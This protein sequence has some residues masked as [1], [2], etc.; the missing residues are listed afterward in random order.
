MTS[1]TLTKT[2]EIIEQHN[3]FMTINFARYP[4]AMV[5]G[6]GSTLWD[7]EGKEY[8]DLFAG[9][10]A[11]VMGHCHPD[12]VEAVTAQAKTLWHV[13][14]LFHTEPQTHLAEAISRHG[15]GGRSFFCH[16]GADANEAAIK[17][18][19][20]Y[21][22]ANPGPQGPRFKVISTIDS[23]HGR[24]FATMMATGQD[25]VRAGYEPWLE[26]FSHVPYNNLGAMKAAID[27]QTV[28]IIVEPIQGEGG[29]NVPDEGYLP[30]LRR[31]AD[32]HNLVLIFDEVWT[33]C[34]RT[35]RYFAHQYWNAVPDVMTL[36]KGVGGGLAVGVMCAGPRVADRFDY[37]VHH[38]VAHATTLGGNCLSMA[39][40]AAVFKVL[41]RDNLVAKA[42][43]LGRHA[44]DR[45]ARFAKICPAV[46]DVRGRGLFIGIELNPA[47]KGAWFKSATEVVNKA[48]ER[49]LLIN[50]TQNTVLRLAPPVVITRQELDRGLDLLE[51]VIANA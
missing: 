13:G 12:I 42:E 15:F 22:R 33:G 31:L 4:I 14:N 30:G 51:R 8:L 45:M 16:S 44:M 26:G 18:S 19:R 36:A 41:E 27:A 11:G 49:G 47:A 38:G 1:D 10:G 28:A 48:M 29:I 34:G 3:K 35:G 21:G 25:K 9:F 46:K 5:R 40:A 2:H 23:F 24:T 6:Q 39:A 37:N 20:L 7:A 43:Q 32:E 50:G 17:L